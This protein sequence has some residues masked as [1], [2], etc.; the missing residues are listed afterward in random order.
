MKI[1]IGR[2]LKVIWGIEIFDAHRVIICYLLSVICHLL[3]ES[4]NASHAR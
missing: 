3:S 2:F 4:N 1:F